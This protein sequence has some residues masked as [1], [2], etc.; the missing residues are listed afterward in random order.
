MNHSVIHISTR[1]ILKTC[2][3]FAG[4]YVIF[5]VWDI[6]LLVFVSLILAALIDPFA[7]MLQKRKIPRGVAVLC[8][9]VVLFSV[10]GSLIAI[11]APVIA[12]D[13]PQ[14]LQHGYAFLDSVQ[15]ESW[16]QQIIGVSFNTNTE[17]VQSTS[18]LSQGSLLGSGGALSGLFSTVSGFVI[19]IVSFILVL[20]I[21]FYMVVQDDPI[22]KILGSIVPDQYVAQV[23][24]VVQ[25]IQKTLALWMRGQLIL[26]VIIGVAVFIGLSLLGIKYAAVIAVL[27]ALFEF[28]PYIG[29]IL[30][31]IPALFFAFIQGGWVTLLFV[32]GLYIIIQ[33]IENHVLVPKIMQHAVGLN[34][35]ISI[36][37]VLVG[38]QLAGIIGALI[39]IPVGASASV[40]IKKLLAWKQS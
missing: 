19:G 10:I 22:Q 23:F 1:T 27:A 29:P 12:R 3:I 20:V 33:Q 11:L 14:L 5:L 31:S 25:E 7:R 24:S 38:M 18:L 32:L 16:W 39:A 4:L 36:V 15:Q 30:A 40:L 35:V 17:A 8:I 2:A 13:V 6:I 28:V 37:A 21:T 26:S 9:Y 34:P